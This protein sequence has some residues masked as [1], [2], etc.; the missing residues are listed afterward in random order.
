MLERP[1]LTLPSTRPNGLSIKKAH[2]W[3][4]RSRQP[5]CHQLLPHQPRLCHRSLVLELGRTAPLRWAPPG[6][7]GGTV[8]ATPLPPRPP[9]PLQTP[10]NPRSW[11]PLGIVPNMGGFIP[12]TWIP[13]NM[14]GL[15]QLTLPPRALPRAHVCTS[16]KTACVLGGLMPITI[17]PP[18]SLAPTTDPHVPIPLARPCTKPHLCPTT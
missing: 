4:R 12:V 3:L 16:T 13:L 18:A 6:G 8:H 7:H 10:P 11:M 15:H 14:G 2:L 5:G 9:L 17:G 1:G